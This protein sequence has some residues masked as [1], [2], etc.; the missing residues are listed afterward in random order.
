MAT[1]GLG[2]MGNVF[3]FD[4]WYVRSLLLLSKSC[5]NFVSK[6]PQTAIN[7]VTTKCMLGSDSA[8]HSSCWRPLLTLADSHYGCQKTRASKEPQQERGGSPQQTLQPA[9]HPHLRAQTQHHL[10]NLFHTNAQ[11]RLCKFCLV[12]SFWFPALRKVSLVRPVPPCSPSEHAKWR[13]PPHAHT[14]LPCQQLPRRPHPPHPQ[15]DTP[16]LASCAPAAKSLVISIHRTQPW[17]AAPCSSLGCASTVCARHRK[18][19]PSSRHSVR[20]PGSTRTRSLLSS[21]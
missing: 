9:S 10:S 3:S 12:P 11:P 18:S 20:L 16:C 1:Q 6:R 2:R 17:Q 21:R 15:P 5:R 14:P 4:L 8:Q 19:L 7:R 13:A